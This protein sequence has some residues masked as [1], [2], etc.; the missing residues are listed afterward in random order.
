L[1]LCSAWCCTSLHVIEYQ[2]NFGHNNT[3][4]DYASWRVLRS[5][6]CVCAL[7]AVKLI[8]ENIFIMR[9]TKA[10][11]CG[12]LNAGRAIFDV[13]HRAI[14]TICAPFNIAPGRAQSINSQNKDRAAWFILFICSDCS[15]CVDVFLRYERGLC[16]MVIRTRMGGWVTSRRTTPRAR[17][18]LARCICTSA[19]RR[20]SWRGAATCSL[21]IAFLR[22]LIDVVWIRCVLICLAF[23]VYILQ[24]PC[25][26]SCP[27][28]VC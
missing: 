6:P 22:N 13:A 16:G 4:W 11:Y 28:N 20:I 23:L 24:Q 18:P 19:N 25:K 3:S 17:I 5:A 7:S 1:H 8:I 26:K 27:R 9:A 2:W 14:I 10:L 21:G 12:A 15:V